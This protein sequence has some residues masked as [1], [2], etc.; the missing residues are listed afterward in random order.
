M[1]EKVKSAILSWFEKVIIDL[2]L[3]PFAKG[4][5]DEG[6]YII[7]VS[8]QVEFPKRLDQAINHITKNF[9]ENERLETS[10]LVFPNCHENFIKFYNF[11]AMLEE[12][13]REKG[14]S[15]L[16][17]VVAFHPEFRFEGEKASSRGNVVNRS[18]Y[19]LIHFLKTRSMDEIVKKYGED[20]GVEISLKNKLVLES[21]NDEEFQERVG[22][23]I[24]GYW[25]K[26]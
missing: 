23:F 24:Y 7:E 17:Q 19:P 12:K 2:N 5:W 25:E 3:C 1:D 18:P 8:D 14:L 11:S 26:K 13:I 6:S 10:F 15:D 22:K 9:F 4:P 20:I 16:V 21:L